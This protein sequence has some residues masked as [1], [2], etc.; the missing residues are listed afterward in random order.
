MKHQLFMGTALPQL[1]DDVL[2]VHVIAYV[3]NWKKQKHFL[4]SLFFNSATSFKAPYNY[5]VNIHLLQK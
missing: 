2:W 3:G 5:A 1:C 4:S